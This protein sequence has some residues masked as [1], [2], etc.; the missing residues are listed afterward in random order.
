[1]KYNIMGLLMNAAMQLKRRDGGT[2]FALLELANNLRLVMREEASIADFRN[3][4][5]GENGDPID[6]E[7]VLPVP[8]VES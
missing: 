4:Y 2:A 1:M 5:T 8:G 3:A 7:A 6:I